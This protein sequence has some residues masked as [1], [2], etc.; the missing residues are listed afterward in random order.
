MPKKPKKTKIPR[1]SEKYP[2]FNLKRQVSNRREILEVDY[3]NQLSEKDKDWLNRFNEEFAL[4]NFNH[5]GKLLDGSKE[6]RKKSYDA[7]NARN[8]CLYTKAKVTGL[9]NNSP[10]ESHLKASIDE[11]ASNIYESYEDALV[12]AIDKR[13]KLKRKPK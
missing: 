2:T 12:G 4:A 9:L 11:K 3:L 1:N 13:R 8:R 7:N 6:A 5:K 10:T